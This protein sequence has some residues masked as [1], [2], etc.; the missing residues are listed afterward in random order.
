MNSPKSKW[1]KNIKVSKNPA[2]QKKVN[3]KNKKDLTKTLNLNE[4][5]KTNKDNNK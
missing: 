3:P 5:T 2:R 4:K 1:L